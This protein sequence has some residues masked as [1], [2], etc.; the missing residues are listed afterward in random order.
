M[1]RRDRE[2]LYDSDPHDDLLFGAAED[3][4]SDDA[5]PAR[6]VGGHREPA[7]GSRRGR[8]VG[9]AAAVIVVLVAAAVWFIG[10]PVYHYLNPPDYSGSGS[11]RAV[12]TIQPNDTTKQIADRLQAAGVIASD[13]AF[14]DVASG[15]DR[16][17]SIQPGSYALHDHMSARSAFNL[18]LDPS[19]RI[20]SD[21]VIP[22]GA[23]IVN[24]EKTLAQP[25]CTGAQSQDRRCG[26]GADRS[27]VKQVPD[28][29]S[30]LGIPTDYEPGGATPQS[31]EGFLFPATYTFGKSTSVSDAVE[32]M[33]GKFT[34]E[35][36]ASRFS[37][38][39]KA[40]G[41]TPYQALTVASIA[42]AEAKFSSDFPKVARVILDHLAKQIPLRVDATS[43]YAAKLRGLIR[44]SRSTPRPG[45]R[46]TPTATRG[47]RRPRSATPAWRP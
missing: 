20:N 32:Q 38:K 25:P 47:C 30:K 45:A 15:D 10:V 8:V 42:Q 41:L 6:R 3:D 24:V 34:D 31:A 27:S 28:Q 23:T 16:A 4:W 33:V 18:L 43:A 29:V 35:A 22:E 17:Q 2:S 14:A 21:T 36:R 13:R 26:L 40:L 7:A 1:P 9:V 39:A 46:S 12:V 5:P 19:S 11:G 44:P 37:A